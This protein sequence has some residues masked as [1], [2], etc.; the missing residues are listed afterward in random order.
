MSHFAPLPSHHT[1]FLLQ[2][3]IQWRN[4]ILSAQIFKIPRAI[5]LG[6]QDISEMGHSP[7]QTHRTEPLYQQVSKG[8]LLDSD[9]S[10]SLQ[11][12]ETSLKKLL[13][14]VFI[15]KHDVNLK[16]NLS[17]AFK[18]KTTVLMEK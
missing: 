9:Q 13:G 7:Q 1:A 14:P 2:Y 15:D 6:V 18:L 11:H 10:P 16:L 3:F 17:V 12:K 8:Q 4:M 5:C